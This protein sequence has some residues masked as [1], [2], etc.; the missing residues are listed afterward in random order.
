MDEEELRNQL[1]QLQDQIKNTPAVDEK[2]TR[3]LR[4]L[5]ADI[6]SL[7]ER[8]QESHVQ[9]HPSFTRRLEGALYHFEVTHPDLTAL[10]SRLMES[11]SNVGI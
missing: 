1:Q 4:E 8:S 2:G 6:R 11:L 7:L 3:L 10:I 9:I 5:D